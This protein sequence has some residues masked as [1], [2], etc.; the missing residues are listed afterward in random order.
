M[1]RSRNRYGAFPEPPV[2]PHASNRPSLGGAIRLLLTNRLFLRILASD[3][4]VT[5]AQ[6]IRAALFIFFVSIHM[7]R[8]AWASGLF[9]LQFVFGI[10]AGP[11][12]MKIGYRLGKHQAA[13]LGELV[14]VV[15]NLGL[16]FV[17]PD[18]LLL[19]LVL[20]TA[21]GLAQGSGNLMRRSMVADVADQHRLET[22]EDR[23]GL[24]FSVFSISMKAPM[25]AAIGIAL[26]SDSPAAE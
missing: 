12:W 24:F 2:A 18:R 8:P 17:A 16:L 26:P 4:A 13:V 9:L 1:Q 19:L 5:L 20:T 22:G 15:V 14:Q 3:F 21:Q 10:A 23:T 25:A 6:S 7:Q 11:L